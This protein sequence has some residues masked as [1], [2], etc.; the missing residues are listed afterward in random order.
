ML[1]PDQALANAPILRGLT[2]EELELVAQQATLRRFR[3][4]DTLLEFGRESPGLFV[5]KSGLVSAL[6]VDE[7]GEEREVANLAK[8]ECVGE[9]ALI[10]G[11][12]PSATVRAVTETEAWL[13][14]RELFVQLFERHPALWQN[15]GYI[16]S[17]RLLRTS[18]Q[19]STRAS[20]STVVLLIDRPEDQT[21]A[22]A[23]AVASSLAR[24]SRKRVLLVDAREG[25]THS[26][27]TIA[28]VEASPSIVRML[29]DGKL[30][31]HHDTPP[32]RTD[33]L[34]GAR[35]AD[36]YDDDLEEPREDEYVT[37]LESLA[38]IYDFV[39]LLNR[40]D[41][42][43]LSPLL[44]ERSRSLLALVTDHADRGIAPWLHE[45]CQI[46]GVKQ[47][48]EVAMLLT[49][50]RASST[51]EDIEDLTEKAVGRITTTGA[52]LKRMADLRSFRL[53][54]SEWRELRKSVDRLARQIGGMKVGLALGAGAAKG[55]AHIGV[56]KLL[57]EQHVPIDCIAGCSIGAVVAAQY[58]WGLSLQEI[59]QV[60]NGADRKLRRWTLPFRS[61]WS[62]AGLKEML[63]KP[64]PR[65]RFRDLPIPFAAIATD[66]VT[67]RE[68]VIRR[69]VV[70]KAIQ[71]S[72]S[73]PGIFPAV[74]RFGKQLVDGGLVNP[75]PSGTVRE[76]GADIVIAVDLMSASARARH[77]RGPSNDRESP[78]TRIPN[79]VEMLLR[80][81]EIMQEEVTLHS[82]ATAD[83]TIEP[84]LEHVRW[85]DFSNRGHEFVALG[86]EAAREKL[87][88]LQA[89]CRLPP[90]VDTPA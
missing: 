6:V 10:T 90:S 46:P 45:L 42:G 62:D 44:L 21:A 13:L 16:L 57:E 81:T 47:K 24:Q 40:N 8:G 9:M 53:D 33:A 86:E 25:T 27:T 12:P 54:G 78:R 20:A 11:E 75:V 37:I 52:T 31:E 69:G 71:A 84:L 76:L 43:A 15:L 89:L 29:R 65:T 64:A 72:T 63:M 28:P 32:K 60:L 39:L 36:L 23:V 38:P 67:G 59:E 19:L 1:K 34:W 77:Q 3:P 56:L 14:E 55:Y 2:P 87:P 26:V 88:E 49:E 7:S 51:L 50:G 58:A 79:L 70:W 73:V 30:L 68:T 80:A 41:P 83:L 48:L 18:R 85:S 35:I 66:V 74:R 4:G 5:L 22:L 82:V 17:Q 61:I